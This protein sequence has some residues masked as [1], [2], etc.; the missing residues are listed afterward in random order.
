MAGEIIKERMVRDLKAEIVV[1]WGSYDNEQEVLRK[2]YL[3]DPKGA[4]LPDEFIGDDVLAEIRN[5]YYYFFAAIRDEIEYLTE[6]FIE[7]WID[8]S[9]E[10]ATTTMMILDDKLLYK[11]YQKAWNFWY[12]SEEAMMDEMYS[13][14]LTLPAKSKK[15][16]DCYTLSELDIQ[17]VAEQKGISL[18]GIDLDDVIHYIKKGISWALDNR[19]EIIAEAIY[20]SKDIKLV[21]EFKQAGRVK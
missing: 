12:E 9:Y 3:T 13:I 4:C 16:W 5:K 19:N 15:T 21:R 7:I 2:M 20:Q 14:Y 8:P 6:R 17:E 18:D 10:D 11:D 1:H